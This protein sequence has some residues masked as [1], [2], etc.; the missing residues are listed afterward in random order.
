MQEIIREAYMREGVDHAD[1]AMVFNVAHMCAQCTYD[2]PYDACCTNCQYNTAQYMNGNVQRAKLM[3]VNAQYQ[4]EYPELRRYYKE[5]EQ[6]YKSSSFA[7]I[8]IAIVLLSIAAGGIHW[9][10][11]QNVKAKQE[12]NARTKAVAAKSV[13]AYDYSEVEKALNSMRG[14]ITDLNG[15]RKINCQDYAALFLRYYPTAQIIYNPAIGPT[16]HVFN[17]VHTPEGW[18]YIEPQQANGVW[19]MRKAW[20]QYESV[21]HLNREV[22]R[23]YAR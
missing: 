21:K 2:Y 18:L 17:R 20:P 14:N 13:P 4:P 1:D 16:G 15:D 19:L 8:L 10:Y 9:V 7:G 11:R 12:W 23:E 5:Q 6:C 22:T 3:R